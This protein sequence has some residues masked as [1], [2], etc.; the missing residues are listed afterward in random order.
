M[1]KIVKSP[2]YDDYTLIK[3]NHVISLTLYN[4]KRTNRT[5]PLSYCS[6]LLLVQALINSEFTYIICNGINLK[7]YG[8]VAESDTFEE[9]IN[10][11]PEY[12]I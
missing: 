7:S 11:F 9:L 4:G 2:N 12:C 3:D 1:I 10:Q 6:L 5:Q 8:I